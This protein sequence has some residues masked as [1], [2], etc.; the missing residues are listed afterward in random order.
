L[1]RERFGAKLERSCM[2]R[3]HAQTGGSTLTAQQPEVN[4]VRVALQAMAA[5]LGGTQSLHTNG[6]D[7]ALSLPTEKSARVALRTQQVIG[8]ESG[9]TEA[10]DPLGGSEYIESLTN[11]IEAGAREYIAR[12]DALGGT[13]AAIEKGY[14]QGEIQNAAYQY[15]R[16]VEEGRQ[17]VVGVN[18]FQ[19]E[20]TEAP[21]TFQIDPQLEKQQVE[22]VRAVR[23]SRSLSEANAMLTRLERAARG[24]E[25]LLPCIFD[26]CRALVTLGEIS[27]T[28]RTVF[29]DYRE[30]F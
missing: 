15:Q 6:Q 2:L 9:V 27:E 16:A 20:P 7:E 10:P 29:G 30:T 28:L 19:S 12:I 26:C 25:N 8:Y 21:K 11:Q 23:A 14:V 24:T 17:I 1:M 5:V 13:L 18:K 4:V 22:R 3:F